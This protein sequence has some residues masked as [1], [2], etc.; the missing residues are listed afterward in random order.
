MMR[1]L[2]ACTARAMLLMLLAFV[3]IGCA[4]TNEPPQGS[5]PADKLRKADTSP[6][7][8]ASFR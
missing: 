4:S 3:F 1:N 7:S 8:I 6:T 2:P 5:A